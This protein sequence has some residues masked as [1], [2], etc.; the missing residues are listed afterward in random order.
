MVKSTPQNFYGKKYIA[1]LV[2]VY[3]GTAWITFFN[4]KPKK[5]NVYALYG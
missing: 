5:V 4:A 3:G 2:Q 1:A